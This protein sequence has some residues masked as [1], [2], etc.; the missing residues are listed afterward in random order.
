MHKLYIICPILFNSL[1]SVFLKHLNYKSEK[2]ILEVNKLFKHY[3]E[4]FIA[5]AYPDQAYLANPSQDE[6][7]EEHIFGTTKFCFPLS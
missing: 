7:L 2:M 5:S 6:S 3:E 4:S 1:L